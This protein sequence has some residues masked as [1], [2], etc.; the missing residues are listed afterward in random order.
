MNS[1]SLFFFPFSFF[2]IRGYNNPRFL[3]PAYSCLLLFLA[4]ALQLFLSLPLSLF[5]S[6][7]F[8]FCSSPSLHFYSFLR[9]P[10]PS[11]RRA[12]LIHSY[13]SSLYTYRLL[14]SL[15]LSLSSFY[16]SISFTFIASPLRSLLFSR[17]L[18][19]HAF[20]CLT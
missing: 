3:T 5:F 19:T 18:F 1:S 9:I 8:L 13:S 2:S 15:S 20:V 11:F 6:V 16:R 17:R 10:V 12:L 7:L 4:S 14:C